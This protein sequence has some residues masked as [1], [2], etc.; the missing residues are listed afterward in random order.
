MHTNS[1]K[2]STAAL[3]VFAT[4]AV[5]VGAG[6]FMFALQAQADTPPSVTTT[7]KNT[8]NTAITSAPIGSVVYA[9]VVVASSS[10]ST[11][12]QG[13]VNFSVFNNT[14]CTGTPSVQ[15]STTLV[16]TSIASSTANSATTTLGAAGLSYKVHYN[17][18]QNNVATD[19]QCVALTPTS[20][21]VSI[22]T[23]LST[24]SAQAGILVHDSATLANI[25]SN[26]SGTVAYSIYGSPSCVSPLTTAGVKS[27]T[28][29]VVPNSDPVLFNTPGTYYWQ[30]V[31]SGDSQNSAATSSCQSE[32]LT[33][34][35]TTTPPIASTTGRI[36]VDKVTHPSGLS[37]SFHF[38]TTGSGYGA[39]DLTDAASPN[40]Q[41]LA[42]GT[43]SIAEQQVSGWKL[44]SATCTR[45]NGSPNSYVPGMP[46]ALNA[47]DTVTCTFVNTLKA[48]STPGHGGRDDDE[49]GDD[50]DGD[51]H[52]KGRGL[53][54]FIRDLVKS[55]FENGHDNRDNS[56][57]EIRDAVK[58]ELRDRIKA[59]FE[60]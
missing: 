5:L 17:G 59:R 43:Y 1:I 6:L 45:N 54:E 58:Q 16:A 21:T 47:G 28:S 35:A 26:A 8:S 38:N 3:A 12:P 30:A 56:N 27:V 46:F 11:S 10:A 29:G 33:I 55:R 25:T 14:S 32:I 36:I 15:A 37:Q 7:I 34:I 20:A 42:T 2:R 39:F 18:D 53:G 48:T 23:T 60:R 9:S 4:G 24:T 40:A 57:K 41:T 50:E 51:N 52:G 49:D 44:T 22:A 13:S 19:G 31:Y